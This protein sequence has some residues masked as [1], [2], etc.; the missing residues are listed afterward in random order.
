MRKAS[1]TEAP[2]PDAKRQRNRDNADGEISVTTLRMVRHQAWATVVLLSGDRSSVSIRRAHSFVQLSRPALYPE[3]SKPAASRMEKVDSGS[4]ADAERI[5]NLAVPEQQTAVFPPVASQETPTGP[6][7]PERALADL[8]L[9]Q[10]RSGAISNDLLSG[11]ASQPG[12][13]TNNYLGYPMRGHF[14]QVPNHNAMLSMSHNNLLSQQL[15]QFPVAAPSPS[16]MPLHL[17]N[18]GG[19]PNLA[20]Q[21]F[22]AGFAAPTPASNLNASALADAVLLA[23]ALHGQP[24]NVTSLPSAASSAG[25][26]L[27]PLTMALLRGANPGLFPDY[28]QASSFQPTN[29]APTFHPQLPSALTVSQATASLSGPNLASAALGH[30]VPLALPTDRG[31][32]SE[33]QSL[34]REQILLFEATKDDIKASAQGRN[35]PIRKGQVGIIC[36]HCAHLNPK[37]RPRGATYFPAKLCGIYRKCALAHSLRLVSM[38]L[39]Q[40]FCFSLHHRLHPCPESAQN[41]SGNHFSD[42]CRTIPEGVRAQMMTHR[43]NKTLVHGGGKAYWM[44]SA[45]AMGVVE[46]EHGLEFRRSR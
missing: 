8:F 18:L 29:T 19:D 31:V 24:T 4:S 39:L 36:K 43:S 32:L 14:P 17:M 38:R 28:L 15:R 21:Q 42:A 27:D 41:M 5:A 46:T 9:S 44:D 34:L 22:S 30:T 13:G 40:E 26:G 2:E 20:L 37:Y 1:Q 35:R 25:G 16:G 3:P 23:R 6:A 12:S 7:A 33:Y 45:T 11:L 10:A